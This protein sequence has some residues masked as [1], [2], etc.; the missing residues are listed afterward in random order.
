[1]PSEL[2]KSLNDAPRL[3]LEAALRPAQGD[4][5]QPTGF[6]DLGAAQ[7]TTPDGRRMLLV[8]SAQSLANRLER[9]VIDGD[10]VD[11]REELRGLPY[12]R[13]KLAGQGEGVVTSSL[14]EAHRL[15]SPFIVTNKDFS[16][17]FGELS[18]YKKGQVI[19]W[20]TAAKAVFHFDPCTLLHGVFFANIEDGRL[21]FPR[22]LTGFIE[23]TDVAEAA[24]GGVKNNHFDPSGE[25]RAEGYDKDVYGNVPYSRLEFTAREIRAYFNLDLAQ[26]RGYQLPPVA[27]ELLVTLALYKVRRFLEVGLRLRTAC[28]LIVKDDLKATAPTGFEIPAL[29]PLRDSLTQLVAAALKEDGLLN[30]T[31]LE[32]S[33]NTVK[34]AAEPKTKGKTKGVESDGASE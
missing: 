7:Y 30:G 21:R 22:L 8:E 6:A 12:V 3:L 13:V 14:V 1:M 24:S 11:L 25:V 31:V 15:N 34:K 19:N 5:F 10:G 23:A 17:R 26:L 9:A 16:K 20:A 4:R 28:D 18:K 2:L 27:Q 32:L 33:T 29:A